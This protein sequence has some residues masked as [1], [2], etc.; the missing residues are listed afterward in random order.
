MNRLILSI[1]LSATCVLAMAQEINNQY[2]I[3]VKSGQLNK[4]VQQINNSNDLRSNQTRILSKDF[5]LVQVTLED[6]DKS[7]EQAL[8]RNPLI[9]GWDYNMKTTKRAIPDDQ[10]FDMQWGLE[11]IEATLAWDVTTGGT[12][13]NGREIVIAVLDDGFDLSHPEIA[14]RI[15]YNLDE[16]PDD[17]IDNDNNGYVDDYAGWN[18]AKQDDSHEYSDNHGIAVAGI[19]GAKSDNEEGIAGI[20]WNVRI[21]P[22]SG[23]GSSGDVVAS[24]QYVLDM[25]RRYNDT[26]GA[27]G[28]YIVATN[29]SAGINETFPTSIPLMNWCE[30]YNKLGEAGIIS[31]GATTNKNVDVDDVGDIPSTCTSEYLI[32]VTNIDIMDTKVAN[33]GFGATHV[34]LGAPGRGTLTLDNDNGYDQTF[35][36]TSAATPNVAG[37]IALLYSVPCKSIADMAI[38]DPAMA[39]QEIKNAIMTGVDANS[40]LENITATGGRLNIYNAIEKL[41]E[42]CEELQ[43]PSEKGPME[44]T[45][46]VTPSND[47]LDISYITPD[48]MIYNLMITDR[49]GRTLRHMEF[50]P[51]SFGRKSITVK[52]LEL[53]S[54]IYFISIYNNNGISTEKQFISNQ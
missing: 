1:L 54:G 16:I 43:L 25:R 18:G 32:T 19:L 5:N 31:A 50:T 41:Q 33:A 13:I 21:L 47:Q 36:G 40:T 46:I 4:F 48:E 15:L 35:G 51:P 23:I 45:K 9:K 53:I 2:I 20:N 29:Y 22:I 26:N 49:A 30:M 44:I 28:A 42:V 7:F 8:D 39:S 11:L 14:D 27:E 37:A 6:T 3:S 12:D 24:Y 10:Y 38:S 34:D 52:N 17:G